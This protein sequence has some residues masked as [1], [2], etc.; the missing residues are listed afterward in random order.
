MF[1]LLAT[2]LPLAAAS[3]I[4]PGVFGVAL[5]ILAGKCPI[6]RS[7][8]YLLGA[9]ITVIIL[10][11]GGYILASNIAEATVDAIEPVADVNT[12]IGIIFIIF[13]ILAL[14]QKEGGSSRRLA[15]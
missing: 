3:T 4:A 11:A 1:E 15:N 10:V 2:I 8:A 12:I 6:Q 9:S 13:G 5:A 7:L 14:V